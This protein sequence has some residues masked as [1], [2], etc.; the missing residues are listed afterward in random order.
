MP[1]MRAFIYNLFFFRRYKVRGG[2]YYPD[3]NTSALTQT[4]LK[5]IESTTNKILCTPMLFFCFLKADIINLEMFASNT[6]KVFLNTTSI[7]RNLVTLKLVFI[8]NIEHKNRLNSFNFKFNYFFSLCKKYKRRH[9]FFIM[10]DQM[11]RFIL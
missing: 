10:K 9:F 2:K 4:L 8:L 1:P 5:I 6:K 11:P 3:K 7:M